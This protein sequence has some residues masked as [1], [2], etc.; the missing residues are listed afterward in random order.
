MI[1]ISVCLFIQTVSILSYFKHF[2]AHVLSIQ[3]SQYLNVDVQSKC[4]IIVICLFLDS[5][6]TLA[7]GIRYK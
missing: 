3:Y 7:L 1:V 6:I 4:M 2:H 5:I